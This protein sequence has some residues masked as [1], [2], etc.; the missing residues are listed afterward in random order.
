MTTDVFRI[1]P[2]TVVVQKPD[3][4][5]SDLDEDLV[6]MSI[7]T[8]RYFGLDSLSREIWDQFDEPRS[9]AEVCS[10]LV[11]RYDVTLE[12]C[13]QDTLAFVEQLVDAKLVEIVAR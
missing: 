5:S 10:R 6:L 4:L 1:A 7:E 12:Q 8:S 13:R 3:L 2:E 11:E 9:I